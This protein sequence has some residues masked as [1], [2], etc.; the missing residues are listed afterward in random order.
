MRIRS[1]PPPQLTEILTNPELS[2]TAKL[3]A[4]HLSG[5]WLDDASA[6]TGGQIAAGLSLDLTDVGSACA[7]LE[8]VG[9]LWSLYSKG[10][11]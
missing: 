5:S 3:I 10:K 6:S 11:P 9:F 2:A 7:E 4:S 1:S 8:S